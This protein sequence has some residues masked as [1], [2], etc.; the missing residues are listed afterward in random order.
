MTSKE[1]RLKKLQEWNQNQKAYIKKRKLEKKL[2]FE[3]LST[4]EKIKALEKELEM[5]F[6]GKGLLLGGKHSYQAI[7]DYDKIIDK[8]I[9]QVE[10]LKEI[11]N[12]G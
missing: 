10:T 6:Y 5:S 4:E 7:K 11:N 3:A 12:E 8:L 2:E 1:I 9:A